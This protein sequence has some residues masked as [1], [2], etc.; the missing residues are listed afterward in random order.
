MFVYDVVLMYQKS[1]MLLLSIM[2]NNGFSS[3]DF[4]NYL[5]RENKY[6]PIIYQQTPSDLNKP[7]QIRMIINGKDGV[8]TV[9]VL[10]EARLIYIFTVQFLYL[11]L[12]GRVYWLT[13]SHETFILFFFSETANQ[14]FLKFGSKTS[15]EHALM[16]GPLH[17][18]QLS[19]SCLLFLQWGYHK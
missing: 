14:S 3:F 4:S 2:K 5:K 8:S 19:T 17:V 16:S 13:L 7:A 12:K 15:C 1:L 6:Q 11:C 18:H 10:C 9:C